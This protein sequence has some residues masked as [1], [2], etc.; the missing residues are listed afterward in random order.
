M[1]EVAFLEPL[2]EEGQPS[3]EDEE[4]DLSKQPDDGEG[5]NDPEV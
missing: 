4:L 5:A 2:E 3:E 1:S